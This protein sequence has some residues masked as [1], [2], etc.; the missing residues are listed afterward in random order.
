MPVP[1]NRALRS[2]P[3]KVMLG[4]EAPARADRVGSRS[5][6]LASSW[7]TPGGRGLCGHCARHWGWEGGAG[8]HEDRA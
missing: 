7:V 5:K 8:A 6:V 2:M 1:R 3:S 4:S